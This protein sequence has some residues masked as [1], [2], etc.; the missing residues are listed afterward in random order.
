MDIGG[1]FNRSVWGALYDESRRNKMLAEPTPEVSK[2]LKTD[3][4]TEM[5]LICRGPRIQI[6]V[7]G[8]QTIDYVETDDTIPQ[9][10]VI[11][12]QIHSG[13]PSEA[14]YRNIRLLTLTS[15][16]TPAPASK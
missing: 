1:A 16:P 10:G 9:D 13:P 8:T 5:R 12:L 3:D 11:G 6:F 4:W 7:N 14:L 15:E 2:S